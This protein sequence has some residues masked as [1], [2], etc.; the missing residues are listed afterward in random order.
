MID[1]SHKAPARLI[2]VEELAPYPTR[3][4]PGARLL[5]RTDWDLHA[6]RPD[7]RTHFPRLSQALAEWLVES[8]V[9]LIG[10]EMPSVA[11]LQDASLQDKDELTA[12]H[13]TLLR[14]EVVI[15]ECLANLRALPPT[16]TLIALPLKIENGGQF[17]RPWRMVDDGPYR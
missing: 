12:V 15:V 10:L 6:D 16:V 11:S 3:I 5:L 13:Q 17:M 8:G 14:G 7:Y 1:L 4:R 2:T 9:W